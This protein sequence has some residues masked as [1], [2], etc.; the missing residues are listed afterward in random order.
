MKSDTFALVVYVSQ[1]A[2]LIFST[3][4]SL[5]LLKHE[6]PLETRKRKRISLIYQKVFGLQWKTRLRTSINAEINRTSTRFMH[7]AG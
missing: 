6:S 4:F 5:T 3:N 7:R 2:L 1:A